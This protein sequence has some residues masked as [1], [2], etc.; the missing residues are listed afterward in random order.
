MGKPDPSERQGNSPRA[1]D[2]ELAQRWM[3]SSDKAAAAE[4]YERYIDRLLKCMGS[5]RTMA[6][7]S[8]ESVAHS[9]FESFFSRVRRRM[10]TFDDDEA[11]WK[12][13]VTIARNKKKMRFR[14]KRETT[15]IDLSDAAGLLRNDGPTPEEVA[16]YSDLR[17]ALDE[18]LNEREQQY[19]LLREHGLKQA[20]IGEQLGITERH[21]RR[22]KK[23]VET[24]A[25][26]FFSQAGQ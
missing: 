8:G 11:I 6:T 1:S 4:I 3:D 19:L 13:L 7:F 14:K 18:R 21:V 22:L 15:G 17:R 23:N 9:A 10:F 16:E 25:W 20:E 5:S 24:K 2:R 12:L 26:L